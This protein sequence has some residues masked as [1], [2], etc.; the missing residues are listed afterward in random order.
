MFITEFKKKTMLYS[1][2]CRCIVNCYFEDCLRVNS[3]NLPSFLA[4]YF[5]GLLPGDYCTG[6]D[7]DIVATNTALIYLRVLVFMLK[8]V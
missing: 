1:I 3:I 2:L 6:L 4:R 7:V 5:E 8:D